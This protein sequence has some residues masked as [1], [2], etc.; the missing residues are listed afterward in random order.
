[1]C[2]FNFE[3]NLPLKR[4]NCYPWQHY[5][6]KLCNPPWQRKTFIFVTKFAQ[7]T[8]RAAHVR[9]ARVPKNSLDLIRNLQSTALAIWLDDTE[10][11][12]AQ[13]V[14]STQNIVI[15]YYRIV[16]YIISVAYLWQFFN[17]LAIMAYC[18]WLYFSQ[19]NVVRDVVQ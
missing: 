17:S 15:C 14:R 10:S 5:K 4:L 2:S 3:F 12:I 13:T 8:L 6:R 11:T 18:C 1:M 19:D 16:V 9:L 7:R